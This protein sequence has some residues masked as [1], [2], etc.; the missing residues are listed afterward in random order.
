[1]IDLAVQLERAKAW[2]RDTCT[3]DFSGY[4]LGKELGL[5]VT[6]H[7]SQVLA[8]L[9][10]LGL[11]EPVHG[12]HGIY[13][14][15][16][17]EV[18]KLDW[19]GAQEAWYP[20]RLPLG[21]DKL[22][23]VRPKNIIVVAGETN[24]GKTLFALQVAHDNLAQNGGQHT[25]VGYFNSE[26]GPDEL[27]ARL[28]GIDATPGAWDGLS[29]YEREREFHAVVRPDGLNIV[30]YMEVS[31]KFYLV[32]DWIQRI[33]ARLTTGVCVV[34]LQKAKGKDTARGGD[35]TLEKARLAVALS[36]NYGVN[37]AKIVKCKNPLNGALNP[38]GKELDYRIERGASVVELTGWRWVAEK[39]RKTLLQQ[40]ER[41]QAAA[42]ERVA[43]WY[44]GD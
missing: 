29:A 13:A 43:E 38:Q 18:R 32:A 14:K 37:I 4:V 34:C 25:Q 12:K 19:Q 7:R 44:P 5:D 11:I 40:Y 33:H 15:V 6:E 20:L 21:L 42:K 22:C 24:A 16:S 8:D 10:T 39:E 9:V 31:D 23:G 1:M 27:R 2:L 36:Y 17:R 26:M 41:D 30:D 3:G 28:T 35:F